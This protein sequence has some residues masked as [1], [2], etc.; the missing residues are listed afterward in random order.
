MKY[1]AD[2]NK[3]WEELVKKGATLGKEYHNGI[4]YRLLSVENRDGAIPTITLGL[5]S[6]ADRL[7]KKTKP[8]SQIKAEYGEDHVMVHC[9][10][11][12]IMVT[13]DNH[14]VYGIKRLTTNLEKGKAGFIGGNLNADEVEVKS[15]HHIGE[16]MAK[17]IQEEA[18]FTPEQQR[19]TFVKLAITESWAAFYFLYRLPF[20]SHLL[21]QLKPNTEFEY[22]TS[23]PVNE[24]ALSHV[25]GNSDFELGKQ[26]VKEMMEKKT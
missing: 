6:Y 24:F 10:V 15:F 22:L 25:K 11:D 21:H 7:F 9:V 14:I 12:A 5:M 3:A 17:E 20:S 8:I 16:M 26:V 4:L 1:Q 2:R 18:Q 19:L 23:Q 13:T